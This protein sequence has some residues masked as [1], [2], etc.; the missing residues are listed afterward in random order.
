MPVLPRLH[1]KSA[2]V[3]LPDPLTP[4]LRL[5]CYSAVSLAVKAR[6]LSAGAPTGQGADENSPGAAAA[7]TR[8]DAQ[9]AQQLLASLFTQLCSPEGV[10]RMVAAGANPLLARGACSLLDGYAAWFGRVQEAP[11]QEAIRL[12]LACMHSAEVRG[13]QLGAPTR[14]LMVPSSVARPPNLPGL[15]LCLT[16]AG[17]V[18]MNEA[19]S[20]PRGPVCITCLLGQ[21]WCSQD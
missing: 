18:L 14:W 1:C 19:R 4:C 7:T 21:C 12:C 9:Q 6:V 2:S 3:A 17:A 10:G 15:Q 20:R 5:P 11:L 16:L 8:Q 13:S